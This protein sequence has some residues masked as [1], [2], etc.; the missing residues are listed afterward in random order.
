MRNGIL[1]KSESEPVT[2]LMG[3]IL[4]ESLRFR[5]LHIFTIPFPQ[6]WL[7]RV[8]FVLEDEG[9]G[10]ITQVSNQGALC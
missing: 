4:L 7:S 1:I 5:T 6:Q 10:D 9:V 3:M 8:I 2:L